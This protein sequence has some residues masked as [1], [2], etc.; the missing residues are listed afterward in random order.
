MTLQCARMEVSPLAVRLVQVLFNPFAVDLVGTAVTGKRMHVPC[1][2]L[3][4]P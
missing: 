1:S 3:E 4:F 2:L